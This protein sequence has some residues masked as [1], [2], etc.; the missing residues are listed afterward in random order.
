MNATE[1]T[2]DSVVQNI[3][4]FKRANQLHD[5]AEVPLYCVTIRELGKRGHTKLAQTLARKVIDEKAALGQSDSGPGVE[6]NGKSVDVRIYS[7]LLEGFCMRRATNDAISLYTE[8]I[9]KHNIL[10]STRALHMMMEMLIS[11]RLNRKRSS[12]SIETEVTSSDAKSTSK[13]ATEDQPPLSL[14]VADIYEEMKSRGKVTIAA[15][16]M[17]LPIIGDKERKISS[18]KNIL[19]E[20]TA[21]KVACNQLT[22]KALLTSAR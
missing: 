2:V 8:A 22:W 3:A 1:Q 13:R 17:L 4:E 15:Y 6:D 14:T 12:Q 18:L 10:P 11:D 9:E 20:I 21:S 16:N 19:S 7:A 5:L